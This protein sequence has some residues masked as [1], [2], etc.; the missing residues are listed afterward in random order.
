MPP[1]GPGTSSLERREK[2]NRPGKKEGRKRVVQRENR[3]WF[4]YPPENSRKEKKN[5]V[6]RGKEKEDCNAGFF[7]L[8]VPA[9]LQPGIPF[10]NASRGKNKAKKS[11]ARV[12]SHYIQRLCRRYR[13]P[14]PGVLRKGKKTWPEG[15]GESGRATTST[16]PPSACSISRMV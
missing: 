12:R 9:Y 5:A 8:P 3:A 6:T 2:K 15:R 13:A 10:I 7:R 1:T 11:G 16:Y 4:I 14:S